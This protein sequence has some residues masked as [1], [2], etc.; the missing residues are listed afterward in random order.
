MNHPGDPHGPLVP[1]ESQTVGTLEAL[2]LDYLAITVGRDEIESCDA[3]RA[4][5][6]LAELLSKPS[7]AARFFE[8]MVITVDG[9]NDVAWE[10]FE[11]PEVRNY[12][13]ELDGR[14]PYWLWF[15]DKSTPTFGWIWRCFAPPFLTP[16]ATAAEHPKVLIDLLQRRW[17]PAMNDIAVF[18]G[19]PERD[20]S[21]LTDR[22]IAQ[23][24]GRRDF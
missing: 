18:A 1:Y 5:S 16:E 21:A 6:N 17:L 4:M 22:A 19:T 2:G 8:R 9:Y 11:I 15:L 14:F 20:I 23:V 13:F 10:L 12:M 24:Q 7:M 3:S